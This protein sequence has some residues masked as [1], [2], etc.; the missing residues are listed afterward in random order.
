MTMHG[1][2]LIASPLSGER[3]DQ[4]GL[5]AHGRAKPGKCTGPISRS[6]STRRRGVTTGISAHDRAADHPH[7]RSAEIGA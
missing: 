4:L 3:A 1:R 5:H 2:G 6:R 7:H